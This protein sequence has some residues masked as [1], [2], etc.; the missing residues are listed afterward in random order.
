M[1]GFFEL[2]E[3]EMHD[4]NPRY[5]GLRKLVEQ[6]PDDVVQRFQ[7]LAIDYTVASVKGDRD[8]NYIIKELTGIDLELAESINAKTY[9]SKS[10][11]ISRM[12]AEMNKKIPDLLDTIRIMTSYS[13]VIFDKLMKAG[14]ISKEQ[15]EELIATFKGIEKDLTKVEKSL[16]GMHDVREVPLEQ[17]YFWS[18]LG[19]DLGTYFLINYSLIDSLKEHLEVLLKGEYQHIL[20]VIAKGH[21]ISELLESYK[22]DNKTYKGLDLMLSTSKGGEDIWVNLS[23]ALRMYEQGK[24]ILEE[25]RRKID[26]F[27]QIL[28]YEIYDCYEEW[29]RKTLRKISSMEQYPK[30]YKSL[31]EKYGI[32]SRMNREITRLNIHTEIN[33]M[34]NADMSYE[35]HCLYESV[36]KGF[37]QITKYRQAIED[38]F[39]EEM[40]ISERF[41]LVGEL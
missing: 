9:F 17:S 41:D 1:R 37:T 40:N 39:D 2:G 23:A 26:T 32:N 7:N 30:A 16:K 31:F 8:N 24:F 35:I 28:D 20:K 15:K 25:K 14:Y 12:I 6:I 34:R 27:T 36:E 10:G 38:L 21:D 19:T 3:V 4:T 5:P 11:D 29:K 33:I 22:T 13:D 18:V